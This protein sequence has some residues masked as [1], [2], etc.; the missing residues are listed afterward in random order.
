[1]QAPSGKVVFIW[2]LYFLVKF[3]AQY[4]LVTFKF[5]HEPILVSF[6]GVHILQFFPASAEFSFFMVYIASQCKFRSVF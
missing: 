6:S 2:N 1:M 3:K 4:Y 5:H